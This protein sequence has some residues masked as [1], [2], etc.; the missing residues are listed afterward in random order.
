LA[1]SASFPPE[2][3]TELDYFFSEIKEKQDALVKKETEEKEAEDAKKA[4]KA[5]KAAEAT[6]AAGAAVAKAAAGDKK[7]AAK[8]AAKKK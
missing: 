7:E 3:K 2:K 8:P 1:S 6:P 4:E 5:A